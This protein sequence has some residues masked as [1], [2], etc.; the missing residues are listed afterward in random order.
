MSKQKVI[1]TTIEDAEALDK[2]RKYAKM[3][4][5]INYQDKYLKKIKGG[6]E[7]VQG[8]PFASVIVIQV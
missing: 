3:G 4:E 7:E 6:W 8:K 5:I 1:R 2:A